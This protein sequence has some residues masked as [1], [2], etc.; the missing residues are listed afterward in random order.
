MRD[1]L[2]ERLS[3]SGADI[4]RNGS[5]PAGL[6][7]TLSVSVRG[8]DAAAL[9]AEIGDRVAASAGAA[10]HGAEVAIS[11]V[12]KAMGVGPEAGMGPVRFSLGRG[13]TRDEI[14]MVVEQLTNVLAAAR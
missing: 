1:R 11:P 6:P 8:V 9:L 4:R 10:C 3:A 5:L 13:T 12:L 2:W 14:D 7:N